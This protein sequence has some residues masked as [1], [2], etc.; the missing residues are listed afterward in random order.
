[1]HRAASSN[2]IHFIGQAQPLTKHLSH[3]HPLIQLVAT[4]E[5]RMIYWGVLE[6][7]GPARRRSQVRPRFLV[8]SLYLEHAIALS[9][10]IFISFALFAHDSPAI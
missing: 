1:V 4:I 5:L 10:E 8:I 9:I 2:Q 7:I 3:C 6:V